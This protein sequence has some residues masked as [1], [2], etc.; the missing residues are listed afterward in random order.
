[1]SYTKMNAMLFCLE[2]DEDTNHTISYKNNHIESIKCL[3]CGIEVKL[4][5]DYINRHYKE[6]IIERV[7][8]KPSRMTKEMEKDITLFFTRLP[9]RVISKP[10]RLFKE[11]Y[12][13]RKD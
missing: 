9:F 5:H 11:L 2:C 6:E 7:L 1:M 3:D 8:S 12:D 10:Y 4:D 13:D